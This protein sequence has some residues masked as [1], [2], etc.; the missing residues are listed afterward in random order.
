MYGIMTYIWLKSRNIYQRKKP[1]LSCF[2]LGRFS[3]AC[4][5]RGDFELDDLKQVRSGGGFV[6]WKKKDVMGFHHLQTQF[7][8]GI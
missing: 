6:S 1:K 5:L 8:Q 7:K 4:D 2:S 3:P